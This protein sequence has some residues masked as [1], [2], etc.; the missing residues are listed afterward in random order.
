MKSKKFLNFLT[1]STLALSTV[2]VLA[3]CNKNNNIEHHFE[4]SAYQ[5]YLTGVSAGSIKDMTYEE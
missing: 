5:V 2:G 3:G 1:R 4:D